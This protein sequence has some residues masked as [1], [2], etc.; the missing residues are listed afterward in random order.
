VFEDQASRHNKQILFT[1]HSP[2]VIERLGLQSSLVAARDASTGES[3]VESLVG[4]ASLDS[5]LAKHGF[6][7]H[8]LLLPSSGVKPL[9]SLLLVLEG[10]DDA[11][12]WPKFMSRTRLPLEKM[13]LIHARNGGWA[14]AGKAAALFKK[15]H[16]LGLPAVRSLLIVESD[17]D[18][19][20]KIKK[21]REYG[22]TKI[23][24]HILPLDIEAYLINASAI[25]SVLGKPP[26]KVQQVVRKAGGKPSKEKLERI[27]ST[28][29][30]K[31]TRDIKKRLAVALPRLP[32]DIRAVT[33]LISNRISDPL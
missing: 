6:M 32:K 16:S 20:T 22:L 23:D 2:V 21:L 33:N 4:F 9:A 10:P 7:T 30:A 12:I 29:R 18:R 5:F 8:E 13:K 3:R 19:D 31:P 11:A 14:E 24:Y 27:M 1:T 17:E 25:S 15:L 28:L 26:K